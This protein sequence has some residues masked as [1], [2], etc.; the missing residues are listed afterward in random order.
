MSPLNSRNIIDPNHL[1]SSY[2]LATIH[3]RRFK[4]ILLSY[5]SCLPFVQNCNILL[6]EQTMLVQLRHIWLGLIWVTDKQV[7]TFMFL[8]T[9]LTL[10]GFL[11]FLG[12][13]WK[14]MGD[15][16]YCKLSLSFSPLSLA[17]PL[18]CYSHVTSSN[19]PKWRP[20]LQASKTTIYL[21]NEMIVYWYAW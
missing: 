7:T 15:G 9:V 3:T 10:C 19:S 11:W 14:F 5:F 8:V 16:T 18:A 1:R 20:C 2:D 4:P 12:W 21:G 17:S 13:K 6:L